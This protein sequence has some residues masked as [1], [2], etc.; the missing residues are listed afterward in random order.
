MNHKECQHGDRG[1][2]WDYIVTN[3]RMSGATRNWERQRRFVLEPSEE[4][5]PDDIMILDL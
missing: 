3:W 2:D 5:W 4:A 1:R